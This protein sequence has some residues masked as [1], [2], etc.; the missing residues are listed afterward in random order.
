MEERGIESGWEGGGGNNLKKRVLGTFLIQN[1]IEGQKRCLPDRMLIFLIYLQ[2][3]LCKKN[4][5]KSEIVKSNFFFV[6]FFVLRTL[7]LVSSL[8][9]YIYM[10]I[11]I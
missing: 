5:Q 1:F 8:L 10:N 2:Q 9:L 7:P 6:F 11:Y 3:Y 4:K